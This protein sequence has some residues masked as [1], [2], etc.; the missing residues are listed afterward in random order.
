MRF[1]APAPSR[2]SPAD[3]RPS[4]VL[5]R[6]CRSRRPCRRPRTRRPHR[7]ERGA[8]ADRA[9]SVAGTDGDLTGEAQADGEFASH[10]DDLV[11]PRA[12]SFRPTGLDSNARVGTPTA[13]GRSRASRA[14]GAAV[15]R[16]RT[17]LGSSRSVTRLSKA[18]RSVSATAV[19]FPPPPLGRPA[20][21]SCHV[22][23]WRRHGWGVNF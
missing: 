9:G 4:R 23:G 5:P 8:S 7:T 1:G 21:R 14:P 13:V 16:H 6:P 2:G 19:T 22:R 15:G 11:H 20:A 18:R 12:S 10:V 17:R 3:S